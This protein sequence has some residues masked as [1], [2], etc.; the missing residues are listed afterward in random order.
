MRDITTAGNRITA[1]LEP[2]AHF[3]LRDSIAFVERSGAVDQLDVFGEDMRSMERVQWVGDA[4]VKL[5]IQEDDGGAPRLTLQAPDG[6][7]AP[8]EA[9]L[10]EAAAIVTRRFW[11]D[12]DM[13][14]VREA[15]SVDT[16]GED[17]VSLF[18]PMRPANYPG[19][20]EA[21]LRSIVHAQIYP[22]FAAQLDTRLRELYGST[23]TFDG[24]PIALFP[25]PEELAEADEVTLRD[26]KFS[27]QKA[28]YLTDIARTLLHEAETYSWQRL[29]S[30]PGQEA[31]ATLK[32]LYGVGKWTSQNV[33]MRGL[34]HI[35]VFIDEKN[36][37]APLAKY[38]SKAREMDK[39]KVLEVTAKFAPYRAIACYYSYSKHFD[40]DQQQP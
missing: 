11:M 38:Y 21:L 36:T 29:R 20:W 34:P 40:V 1:T 35:D 31:V 32:N 26:H 10:R 27:R 37:R 9:T 33:A 23:A 30:L 13:D 25:R 17:L 39:K 28:R 22:P 7:E 5:R 19:P 18:W 12:A 16:Y 6:E 15:L 14:A 8:R 2:T 24:Q 3:R 4:I